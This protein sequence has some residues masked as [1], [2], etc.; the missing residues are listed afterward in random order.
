MEGVQ[1]AIG[2]LCIH[3]GYGDGVGEGGIV[4]LSGSAAVPSQQ[5]KRANN[6]QN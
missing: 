6:N 4:Y 1:S 2:C 3:G 5:G